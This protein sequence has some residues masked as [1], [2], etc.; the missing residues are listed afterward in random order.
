M[1]EFRDFYPGVENNPGS[2]QRGIVNTS[3]GISQRTKG[4]GYCLHHRIRF[5]SGGGGIVK[6]NHRLTSNQTAVDA[7][8]GDALFLHQCGE[9]FFTA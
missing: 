7:L 2:I 1:E 5:P 4:I 8:V 3:A 9:G 6:I